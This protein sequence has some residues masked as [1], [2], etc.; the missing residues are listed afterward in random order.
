MEIPTTRQDCLLRAEP[1]THLPIPCTAYLQNMVWP[2]RP[3]Q[4]HLSSTDLG[5]LD[6]VRLWCSLQVPVIIDKNQGDKWVND[7]WAIAK[8]LEDTYPDRD[9]LFEGPNGM[10][11]AHGCDT[12]QSAVE[13]MQ[14]PW[15]GALAPLQWM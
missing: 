15:T 12:Y 6:A 3:R 11:S 8:Y 2:S 5:Y 10:S 7:S 13:L 4:Y 1:G 9:A 14:Y